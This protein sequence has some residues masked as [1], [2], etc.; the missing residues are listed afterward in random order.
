[1]QHK[2]LQDGYFG[3]QCQYATQIP[4]LPGVAP[5][6]RQCG[7]QQFVSREA[8][9]SGCVDCFCMAIPG[10]SCAASTLYRAKLRASLDTEDELSLVDSTM[11]TVV[12]SGELTYNLTNRE[13]SY[14]R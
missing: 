4:D 9:V 6:P 10:A 5:Q 8:A 14:D 1:M 12:S 7:E 13:V 3:P 2:M 11:A